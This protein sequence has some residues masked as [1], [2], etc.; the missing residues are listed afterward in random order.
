MLINGT[1]TKGRITRWLED[2]GYGF[3]QPEDG[4]RDVFAH[5][6]A[7]FPS[8]FRVQIGMMVE[9]VVEEHDGR[10]RA[11]RVRQ[12]EGDVPLPDSIFRA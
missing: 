10:L 2:K 6:R 3:I 5:R 7:L 8:A 11:S 4:G 12:I 1:T 9:Y